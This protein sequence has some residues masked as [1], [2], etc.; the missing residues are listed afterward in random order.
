MLGGIAPIIIFT[1]PPNESKKIGVDLSKVLGGIPLVGEG[2]KDPFNGVGLPIPIYLDEN[3]TGI[4]IESESKSLDID[5]DITPVYRSSKDNTVTNLINQSGLNNLVTVNMLASR[6]SILLAVL[7]SLADMAF[8]QLV[9]GGY[10]I[11]YING[12]TVIFGGLLHSFSTSESSDDTLIKINL[13]I[14]KNN[15]NKTKQVSNPYVNV[16]PV[17]A[18]KPPTVTP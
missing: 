3:L 5:T 9:S 4:Y 12:A 6:D 15:G 7:L 2:A 14:Q 10:S 8:N 17:R 11:S 16:E 18:L 13:Q 1:F